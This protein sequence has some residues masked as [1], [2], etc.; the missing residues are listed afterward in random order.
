MSGD[1]VGATVVRRDQHLLLGGMC[2]DPAERTGGDER[3]VG[4]DDGPGSLPH[5]S[6][7]N[8]GLRGAV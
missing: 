2:E 6:F 8:H 1:D 7:D 5:N 4:V 3:K